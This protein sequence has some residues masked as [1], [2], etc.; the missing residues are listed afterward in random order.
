MSTR[1]VTIQRKA[2]AFGHN[3]GR[4]TSDEVIAERCCFFHAHPGSEWVEVG[5][6]EIALILHDRREMTTKAVDSLKAQAEAVRAEA[7]RRLTEIQEQINSLL[8]I[9]HVKEAA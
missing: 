6:A 1:M 7:G 8:A 2:F 4:D 5:T 9:E 3:I